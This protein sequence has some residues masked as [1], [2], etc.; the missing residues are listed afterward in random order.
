MQKFIEKVISMIKKIILFQNNE[1][2]L[3][4]FDNIDV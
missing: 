3:N 2:L 4:N 1:I